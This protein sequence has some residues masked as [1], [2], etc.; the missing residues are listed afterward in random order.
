MDNIVVGMI[1]KAGAGKD[2]VGDYLCD[3]YGFKRVAF[4]DPL[5]KGVKAIFDLTD[6]QAYDRVEREKPLEYFPD[7]SPRK[8][9]Q[10][11]GT[12]LLRDNF[13]DDIWIKLFRKAVANIDSDRVIITDMR[14]PNELKEV[15]AYSNSYAFK[16]TRP[17]YIGTNVGIS[18]HASESHD[19]QGDLLLENDGTIEDLYCKVDNVMRQIL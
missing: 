19:L 3:N 4:A 12:E 2:T 18:N 9:F 8:L 10:Y 17:N 16:V 14:F 11:F 15:K 6:K 7:W 1:G 5:K 13:D